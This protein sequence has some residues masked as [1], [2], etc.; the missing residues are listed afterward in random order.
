[1]HQD[2]K[3]ENVLI[4]TEI[5]R[6]IAY[7]GDVGVAKKFNTEGS[8]KKAQTLTTRTGTEEW[9]A[10]EMRNPNIIKLG[11]TGEDN[12]IDF[13]KLDIFSLGLITLYCLDSPKNFYKYS[14]I[15]NEK[16]RTLHE[17]YLPQLKSN[18]PIEFFCLLKS[19]LS[20]D[21]NARPSLD[22]IE[23]FTKVFLVKIQNF[24][25]QIT[26]IISGMY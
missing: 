7:L 18:M 21:W 24:F 10:P 23:T 6:P 8:L 4:K 11:K 26:S 5:E 2:L 3:P 25:N 17:E 13:S 20:F 22:E 1:M 12:K 9:M 19:I 14:P 15:L 16:S